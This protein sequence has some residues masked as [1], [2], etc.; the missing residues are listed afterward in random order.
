MKPRIV[1]LYTELAGYFLACLDELIRA[2]K[3]HVSVIHLRIN[4]EA[5]FEFNAGNGIDMY[6]KQA[7]SEKE[8][9]GLVG[10]ISPDLIFCSGWIDK[11]YLKICRKY[12]GSVPTVMGL[13]TSWKGSLKQQ[14]ASMLSPIYLGKCFSHVWV[15]GNSQQDYARKLGFQDSNIRKGFYSA[16]FELFHS[17]YKHSIK[18]KEATF[19][20][21]FIYAARYVEHKGI[22][23]LWRAFIE[24]QE[25]SPNDW[26]LWCVGTGELA[27]NAPK[28]KKIIH[29]GFVQP[30]DFSDYISKTGVFVLPSHFEPWGVA[31]HEFAAA[32]YPLICSDEVGATEAFLEQEV[33]GYIHKSKDVSSL[34][35]AMRKMMHQSDEALMQMGRKSI[36]LAKKITPEIWADTLMKL[37]E[38]NE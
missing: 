35:E 20:K 37:L 8:L 21:R 7:Y 28:H 13:D 15:T 2:G 16:D 26:E 32:G 30:N 3:V 22:K 38:D 25:E 4:K 10:K 36:E 18:E 24:L 29:C 11:D 31:V 5:P 9:F 34:K 17:Y 27:D 12:K 33:N 6:D 14:I 19:P 1:F 23:D